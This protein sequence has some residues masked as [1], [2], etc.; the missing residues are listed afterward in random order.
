MHTNVISSFYFLPA[1]LTTTYNP[2]SLE[3]LNFLVTMLFIQLGKP[4]LISY[5]LFVKRK[6][7]NLR[8]PTVTPNQQKAAKQPI[9]QSDL[10]RRETT[11]YSHHYHQLHNKFFVHIISELYATTKKQHKP[12]KKYNKRGEKRG[13]MR[14][15]EKIRE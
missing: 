4:P 6:S 14:S 5:C 2:F 9:A 1:L 11:H 10:S 3:K 8:P 12:K 13:K 7:K 15:K